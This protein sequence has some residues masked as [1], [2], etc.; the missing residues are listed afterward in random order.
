MGALPVLVLAVPLVVV[1][2][3]GRFVQVAVAGAALGCF[4]M[5][6]LFVFSD[7]SFA[8][9][10][11]A[12]ALGMLGTLFWIAGASVGWLSWERRQREST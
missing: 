4:G 9:L 2:L 12:V 11:A 1:A 6:A 5:L 7:H 3:T 10:F 8:D